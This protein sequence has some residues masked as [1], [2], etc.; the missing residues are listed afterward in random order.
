MAGKILELAIAIRGKLD[1]SLPGSFSKLSSSMRELT[2]KSAELN[3]INSQSNKWKTQALAVRE[4]SQQLRQAEA[5]VRSHQIALRSSGGATEEARQ[6]YAMAKAQVE[7]LSGALDVNREK[8]RQIGTELHNAGFNTSQ[9]AKSQKDL[10]AKIDQNNKVRS[11]RA[12]VEEAQGRQSQAGADLAASTISF[13]GAVNVVKKIAAPVMD[14]IDTAADFQAAMSKVQAITRASDADAAKLTANAR[15]L[16]ETTRY[17]AREAADTMSYLGMAGWNTNQ[18]IAGMPGLLALAAAGGTDLATTADIVSDDLTAFGMS[19]EQAGHMADVFAVA[20]TRT[21]TNVSLIGESMKMAAPVANAYGATMEET[22]ALIGVMANAGIKGS[23]AGTALRAGFLRLAG[24]P[25]KAQKAMEELGISM[26]DVTR[27][28]QEAQAALQS[29][30]IDMNSFSGDG[31][32][33]MVGIITALRDKTK[34]LGNEEKLSALQAIFGTTAAAGWLNVLNAG[35]EVFSDLVK[36][37]EQSDGAAAKMAKTMLNNAKGASVLMQSAFEGASISI[38]NIFLPTLT[39][40]MLLAA[41]AASM[42]SEFAT[43]HPQLVGAIVAIAGA[44]AGLVVVLLGLAV[45]KNLFTYV[46]TSLNLFSVAMKG[47]TAASSLLQGAQAALNAVMS[48]NPAI[49]VA[50]A[51]MAL[52]GYLVYLYNTNEEVRQAFDEAWKY[53]KNLVV[54]FGKT[55]MEKGAAFCAFLAAGWEFISS[56]ASNAWNAI[57]STVQSVW[58]SFTSIIQNGVNW[59]RQ[60]WAELKSIFSTPIDAV[61]NFIKGGDSEAKAAAVKAKRS[62]TGGVFS[63]PALTWV[64]EAGDSEVIVPI[65]RTQ[66][67]MDLWQTA[68]SMLGVLPSAMATPALEPVK[69]PIS[70]SSG[71]SMNVTFAPT[72][73]VSGGGADVA[74]QIKA[75]LME[76]EAQ[77]EARFKRMYDNMQARERRLS[78]G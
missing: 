25:K 46:T 58:D 76:Q 65:N 30:G 32:H 19:A 8:L 5:A 21:N 27:E 28:Q 24:P 37:M 33:K 68:G 22:A 26:S 71:H 43:T 14:A 78:F 66:R 54:G 9:F 38:G 53:M 10:Q 47:A 3:R 41:K 49:L 48:L 16:G 52:I 67:A 39:K 31:A 73:N 42:F 62:A 63:S 72:I 61:V 20:S 2:Q 13:Q 4:L 57:T 74:E 55:V 75:A 64:A 69:A 17:S 11:Q 70:A 29:L 51:I 15:K 18:I 50:M 44:V 36:Q 23:Q 12:R 34:G 77:F 1:G 40:A 7:K 45:L 35:P 6:G 60:K 56:S 59:V